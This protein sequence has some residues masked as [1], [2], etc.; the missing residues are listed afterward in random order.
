MSTVK[1]Q[2]LIPVQIAQVPKLAAEGWTVE[3]IANKFTA[4]I[5][6]V[7]RFYPTPTKKAEKIEDEL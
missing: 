5:E 2:G 6:A 3:Q 7:E 4:T 1:R